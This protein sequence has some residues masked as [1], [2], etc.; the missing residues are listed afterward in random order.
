MELPADCYS[1]L[2]RVHQ[3]LELKTEVTRSTSTASTKK[4][5]RWCESH[6]LPTTDWCSGKQA[7]FTT[8]VLHRINELLSQLN[9][10]AIHEAVAGQRRIEQA[11]MGSR[12]NKSYGRPKQGRLLLLAANKQQ[13]RF[14]ELKKAPTEFFLDVTLEQLDLN[15]YA[16]VLVVENLDC[17]YQA[18]E[19]HRQR[20][21]VLPQSCLQKALII[22]R[23]DGHDSATVVKLV[24]QFRQADKQCVYWGDFD[25]AGICIAL[26]NHYSHLLL[27]SLDSLQ[28][29]A[30]AEHNDARQ[31]SQFE[32]LLQQTQL[33]QDGSALKPFLNLLRND[34]RALK[35]QA[36]QGTL[37]TVPLA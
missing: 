21:Y 25:A 32:W 33:V 10:P 22:Y 20:H 13:W 14:P 18:I 8:P 2:Q 26:Q 7:R 1:L 28:Q 17:F 30:Y 12:A 4:L 6:E 5:K 24:K 31:V 3:E 35:Q 9:Q 29:H 34:M 37:Q 19:L 23:G 27:P 11:L 15:A 36:F 16:S